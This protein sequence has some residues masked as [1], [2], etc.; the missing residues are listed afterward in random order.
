MRFNAI[1]LYAVPFPISNVSVPVLAAIVIDKGPSIKL[2]EDAPVIVPDAPIVKV[3]VD[4][5]VTLAPKVSVPFTVVGLAKVIAVLP[6]VK[7]VY[8]FVLAA[9]AIPPFVIKVELLLVTVPFKLTVVAAILGETPEETTTNPPE[10]SVKVPNLSLA[11]R[12]IVTLFIVSVAPELTVSVPVPA[13]PPS[14]R[15]VPP[16][17]AS[18]VKFPTAT[19]IAP[20]LKLVLKVATSEEEFIDTSNVKSL[21]LTGTPHS[22]EVVISL[23]VPVICN[24][25]EVVVKKVN[26]LFNPVLFAPGIFPDTPV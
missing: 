5:V 22:P 3:F 19:N 25:P 9:L 8:V 12:A 10:L 24:L 16:A 18:I 1:C 14:G 4:E 26:E 11:V 6:V 23:L 7:L 15:K 20:A 13:D 2:V 17:V 21:Q